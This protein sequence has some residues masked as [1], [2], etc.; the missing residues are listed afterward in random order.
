MSA[1]EKNDLSLDYLE[2]NNFIASFRNLN[3]KVK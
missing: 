3:I 1:K 2:I